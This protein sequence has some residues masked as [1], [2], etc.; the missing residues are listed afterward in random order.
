MNSFFLDQHGCAKN[1]VDGEI[2]ITRLLNKGFT[3]V[4]DPKDA[5]LI[6]INTCGF[7]ESAKQES[8]ESVFAAREEY[9]DAKI[10][11]CGCLAER[12]AEVFSEELSSEVDAILGNGDLSLLDE[13][14]EELNQGKTH[15]LKKAPQIGVCSQE[16]KTLL[17]FPNSA[18][19][20]ITE[21]CNNCCSFCAIPVIR[22]NLRSRSEEEIILEIKNLIAKGIFEINLV[23]QDL[24][25]FGRDG[26]PVGKSNHPIYFDGKSP[27][28]DVCTPSKGRA[29]WSCLRSYYM[30]YSLRSRG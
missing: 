18:Y 7:I 1:Q 5:N 13:V 30:V 25:A 29:C 17:G 26:I 15:I 6:L 21:G 9:P 24:A 12:Y 11:L 28:S 16:R 14:V 4:E 3:R 19:V 23:G 20:K 10:V 2:L 22:G 27:L 8:L